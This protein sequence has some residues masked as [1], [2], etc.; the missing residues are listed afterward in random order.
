MPKTVRIA[1]LVGGVATC[2]GGVAATR[3]A[4]RA[5]NAAPSARPPAGSTPRRTRYCV[6]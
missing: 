5:K 2:L 3:K 4:A 1:L 6:G